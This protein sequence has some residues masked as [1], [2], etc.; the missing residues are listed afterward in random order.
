MWHIEVTL[1]N[2]HIVYCSTYRIR[3][4]QSF[5]I[6]TIPYGETMDA[7][8]CQWPRKGKAL[9]EEAESEDVKS[10]GYFLLIWRFCQA[11]KTIVPQVNPH[12]MVSLLR[13]APSLA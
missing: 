3:H 12:K 5:L 8:M 7:G 10:T 9:E 11:V 6:F 13:S 2:P 1:L 4:W